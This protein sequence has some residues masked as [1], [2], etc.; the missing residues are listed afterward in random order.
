MHFIGILDGKARTWGV[1]IP[2]LPGCH[3]GGRTAEAAILD[4]T[5]AVK[6]WIEH[7]RSA[8]GRIPKPRSVDEIREDAEAEFDPRKEVMVLIPARVLEPV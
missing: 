5:S 6:E 4:A 3:G 7:R 8:N 1:R 2:D